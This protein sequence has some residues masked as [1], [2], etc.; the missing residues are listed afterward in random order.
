MQDPPLT[1]G[2]VASRLGVPTWQ[3]RRLFERGLLPPASRVGPYRVF[4]AEDL[5]RVK[6]ALEQAGYL[7]GP[8]EVANV[9]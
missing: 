6:Q 1:V 4:F 8:K 9:G 7:S 5:P 3:I 2:A